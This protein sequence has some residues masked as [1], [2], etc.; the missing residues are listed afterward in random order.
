QLTTLSTCFPGIR[1]YRENAEAVAQADIVVLAVK[2]QI[3]A[4]VARELAP[5]IDASRHLMISIA[6]G[7][8]SSDIDRWLGGNKA[9]VRC[10][11]NTPALVQSGATGLYANELVSDEQRNQ[12]ESVLRSVGST[13]W[14]DDESQIDAVTA[15][16]GSGP[17][18]LF[19]VME[20]MEEAGVQLGLDREAARLLSI[21]TAFGAAKLA[22][23]SDDDPATLRQ[24][25]TSPGGT[26]EQAIKLMEDKQLRLIFAEAMKA[27]ADRAAELAEQL[28]AE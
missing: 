3:L 15:V 12:A 4:T 8:R 25:V 26:T 17:A 13:L 16:S 20:A 18:Y 9:V 21:E 2:P 1:T 22:L 7:L 14:V 23:E 5:S 28:G 6:A 24:K 11:P 19:L 10:M 27:A